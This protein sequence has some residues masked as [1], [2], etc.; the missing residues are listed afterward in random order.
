MILIKPLGQSF[1][2][3]NTLKD[4][5]M[6]G[7]KIIKDETGQSDL[8]IQHPDI[9][10]RLRNGCGSVALVPPALDPLFFP[11][12]ASELCLDL[13]ASRA[14]DVRALSIHDEFHAASFAGAVFF[15]AMLFEAAPLEVAASENDLFVEAHVAASRICRSGGLIFCGLRL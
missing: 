8:L 10:D 15:V 1:P 6:S 11:G 3:Q 9:F 7:Y 2:M 13:T 4:D 12:S 5:K 14:L